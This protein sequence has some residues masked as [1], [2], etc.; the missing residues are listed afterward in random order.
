MLLLCSHRQ[1]IRG[2]AR[3]WES[4]SA[5]ESHCHSVIPLFLL[6]A[7]KGLFRRQHLISASRGISTSIN[8]TSVGCVGEV[9]SCEN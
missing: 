9:C 3:A 5:V 7:V 1:L 8:G 6:S 2:Y 4:D